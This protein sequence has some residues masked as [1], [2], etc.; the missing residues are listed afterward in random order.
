MIRAI[1]DINS[2]AAAGLLAVVAAC[3]VF[4]AARDSALMAAEHDAVALVERVTD[5]AGTI[6]SLSC[7]FERTHFWADMDLRQHIRGQLWLREPRHLRVE[8]TDLTIVTDGITTW[9]YLPRSNQVQV[10]DFAENGEVYLSPHVV[11]SRY[12]DVR[13]PVFLGTEAIGGR[14]CDIV[15]LL[16]EDPDGKRVTVW[17]DSERAIPLKTV[18]ETPGGDVTTHVLS[19]VAVNPDLPDSLFTFE[20]PPDTEVLDLRE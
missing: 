2:R 13:R 14:D 6:T 18:E 11:M 16:T 15:E 17:I 3:T 20:T 10:Y 12:V 4:A 1:P 7:A 19:D 9:N 5:I 8:K